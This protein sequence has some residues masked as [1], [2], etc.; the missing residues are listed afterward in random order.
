MVESRTE[1]RLR[2][3]FLTERFVEVFREK[4]P[5]IR[6]F[7]RMFH[8]NPPEREGEGGGGWGGER[9]REREREREKGGFSVV[10]HVSLWRTI[11]DAFDTVLRPWAWDNV[12]EEG[13][14]VNVWRIL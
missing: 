5:W 11:C 3:T 12:I 14:K 8:I 7:D 10:T 1:A 6:I 4:P 9:E 2:E 13:M